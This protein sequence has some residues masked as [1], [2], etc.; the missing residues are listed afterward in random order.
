M[1]TPQSLGAC[2][3]A[4][5]INLSPLLHLSIIYTCIAMNNP[6]PQPAAN[7]P[8]A[9]PLNTPPDDADSSSMSEV[10]SI[11]SWDTENE[12]SDED[13]AKE[14]N[15][16]EADPREDEEYWEEDTAADAWLARHPGGTRLLYPELFAVKPRGREVVTPSRDPNRTSFLLRLPAEIRNQIYEHY[17]DR[18]EE[19]KRPEEEHAPFLDLDGKEIQ[20]IHL[21]S[22]DVELKFW[23]STA[24][25]QASR[26]L[27]FEAM[28]ILFKNRVI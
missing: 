26:Q 13:D 6:A 2:L 1:A 4:R 12:A 27:R 20:R 18:H 23:L 28:S 11:G 22:E 3:A 16:S 10:V 24:L 21:S 7:I 25:L 17:F 15:E 14:S 5:Y 8:A 9:V 19:V